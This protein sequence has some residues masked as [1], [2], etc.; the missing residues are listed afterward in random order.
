M[1]KNGRSVWGG[2]QLRE[3]DDLFRAVICT[4]WSAKAVSLRQ[5]ELSILT[6]DINVHRVY[7]FWFIIKIKSNWV[8]ICKYVTYKRREGRLDRFPSRKCQ[9]AD[10]SSVW[11]PRDKRRLIWFITKVFPQPWL[12]LSC[13]VGGYNWL[14]SSRVIS[15]NYATHNGTSALKSIFV[16]SFGRLLRIKSI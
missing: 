8:W 7:S 12:P 6:V 10:F 5:D 1:L 4:G 3:A 11:A 15:S 13:R 14:S 16:V 9:A 2:M